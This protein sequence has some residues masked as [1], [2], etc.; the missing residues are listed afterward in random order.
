MVIVA[1]TF[2]GIEVMALYILPVIYLN[3]L[4]TDRFRNSIQGVYGMIVSG[5]AK[6][7]G[8]QAA[9]L[10]AAKS[11]GSVFYWGAGTC[12]GRDCYFFDRFPSYESARFG[13]PRGT[14]KCGRGSSPIF[15]ICAAVEIFICSSDQSSSGNFREILQG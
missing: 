4:A 10:I 13:Y 15:T 2:H 14:M 8:Y 11:L 5:V 7:V 1:Q 12:S 3:S 6:I 9:G